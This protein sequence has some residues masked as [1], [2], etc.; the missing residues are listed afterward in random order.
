MRGIC[1]NVIF[2]AKSKYA[3]TIRF[4]CFY[5]QFRRRMTMNCVMHFILNCCVESPGRCRILIVI[6]CLIVSVNL[7]FFIVM[8]ICNIQLIHLPFKTCFNRF[9][10]IYCVIK[11][12]SL[13]ILLTAAICFL[14]LI[15]SITLTHSPLCSLSCHNTL[16]TCKLFSH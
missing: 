3:V 11:I 7:I 1:L 6:G 5:N 13:K 14:L 12:S 2:S 16:Y 10:L 9:R 8:I 4:S 15:S